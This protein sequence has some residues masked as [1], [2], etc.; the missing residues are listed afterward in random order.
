MKQASVIT[1]GC[2]VNTYD[3]A[4]IWEGLEEKGYRVSDRMDYADLYV[5]NTCTVTNNASSQSRQ[6]IRKV[7][8]LNPDSVV[9]VTGCYAQVSPEEIQAMNDATYLVGN[10]EKGAIADLLEKVDRNVQVN[11]GVGDIS[12]LDKIEYKPIRRF[13]GKSRA[14]L[15]V[16]DGCEAYCSYCIIPYARGKSRSL[17]LE[18]VEDQVLTLAEAGHSEIILTGIHLGGYGLDLPGGNNLLSLLRRLDNL[19]IGVRFR[20]SSL[21]PTEIDDALLEFLCSSK[22]ICR[23]LHIPLQ[24]GDAGTLK[25]MGRKY[26]PD[27][28]RKRINKIASSWNGVAIGIDVIAGFPGE[29]EEAFLNSYRLLEELPAAYLHVFPY[30]KREGTP[31]AAMLE[32]VA[33][34]EIKK[35]CASLRRLGEA[36]KDA[37]CRSFLGKRLNSVVIETKKGQVK[38]LSD[39]YIEAFLEKQ[40]RCPDGNFNV[41]LEHIANNR[42]FGT[43]DGDNGKSLDVC[44]EAH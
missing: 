36:K 12:R 27:F 44:N 1:L 14:F 3:T 26:T 17:S 33:K 15:R 41:R 7:K 40:V 21:E 37:F 13:H 28:Y 22:K 8:K 11:P 24:S 34:P 20:V 10:G 30:S 42:C 25:R 4:L 5:I 9:V 16:Q 18:A 39:N 6:V 43:L 32:Q 19:D 23:H 35:R 29:S 38:T 31:A 2:K